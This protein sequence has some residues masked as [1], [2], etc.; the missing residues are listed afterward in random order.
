MVRRPPHAGLLDHLAAAG[1]AAQRRRWRWRSRRSPARR[2][3]RRSR[4]ARSARS[5]A[6]WGSI[7]FGIGTATLLFTARLPFAIGVAFGLAALLA[8]QR[9]RYALG[10][11]LRDPLAARQPGGGAVPGDG[12]RGRRARGQRRPRQALGGPRDRRRGVHPAGVPVLGLPRGRLGAVPDLGLPAD[13][14]VRDHLRDPAAARAARAALGRDP[15]RARRDDRAA[16]RDADGRQRRAPRR[17]VRRPGDAV[18]ALGPAGL[19]QAVARSAAGRRV[20][21]ARASGCGRRRC[22]T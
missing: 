19:A 3:S 13:P 1:L 15:V 5:A 14:A 10:D 21:V 17:A 22:A 4:A 9:R 2:C 12:R 11:R 16:A 7:W 8:L 20:R 18:R 6:R